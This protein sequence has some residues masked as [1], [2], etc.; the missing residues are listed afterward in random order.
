MTHC[1]IYHD[2]VIG[3]NCFIGHRAAIRPF[4]K[5]GDNTLIG[6]CTRAREDKKDVFQALVLNTPKKG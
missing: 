6:R 5:I 1:Y 2:V 3:E 4:S